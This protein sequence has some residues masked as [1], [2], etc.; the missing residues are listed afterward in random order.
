LCGFG[1]G[2]S[3]RAMSQKPGGVGIYTC[4]GIAVEVMTSTCVHCAKITDIQSRKRML[5]VVDICRQCMRLIC[6]DC[7][8]KPCSPWQKK[9]EAIEESAYR[10]E[11][12]RKSMGV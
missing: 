12:F 1:G 2:R 3:F 10:Q 6:A 11:Q 8:G 4:D 5:D 7:A 9:I